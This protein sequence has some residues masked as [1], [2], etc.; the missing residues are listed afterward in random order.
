M[1]KSTIKI[2]DKDAPANRQRTKREKR[3]VITTKPQGILRLRGDESENKGK[4]E[5]K[6]ERIT[7]RLDEAKGRREE[8]KLSRGRT[9]GAGNV[10][11]ADVRKVYG[12]G[13]AC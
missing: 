4:T 5:G 9:T 12:R 7:P 6:T 10:I 3:R 2:Y 8:E 1:D 13:R 11:L